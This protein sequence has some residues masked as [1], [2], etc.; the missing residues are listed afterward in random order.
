MR[1]TLA[2]SKRLFM[3]IMSLYLFF[4]AYNQQQAR[5]YY[6]FYSNHYQKL[7]KRMKHGKACD[8]GYHFNVVRRNGISSSAMS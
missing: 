4:N 8:T 1:K 6:S 7:A 3:H 2:F 5:H